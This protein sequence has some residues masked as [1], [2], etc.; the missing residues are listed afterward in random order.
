MRL[1]RYL[2]LPAVLALVLGGGEPAATCCGPDYVK[3]PTPVQH[4]IVRGDRF[5][6]VTADG[7]LLAVDLRKMKVKEFPSLAKLGPMVD[8]RG[9]AICVSAGQKLL[10]VNADTGKITQELEIDGPLHAFGF[11]GDD[12][13]F[14]H[15]ARALDLID[16]KTARA[17]T[18]I[19]PG[20]TKQVASVDR[21]AQGTTSDAA[22]KHVYTLVSGEKP[23]VAV[24]D[25]A[26]A[27]VI[28][29]RPIAVDREF[30]HSD[31]QI[32]GKKMYYLNSINSYGIWLGDHLGCIDLQTGK[33]QQLKLPAGL[34]AHG[35]LCAGPDGSIYLSTRALNGEPR[36]MFRYDAEGKLVGQVSANGGVVV[37]FWAGDAVTL[38]RD[39][40]YWG[41]PVQAVN[42]KQTVSPEAKP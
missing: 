38:A 28:E 19:E 35:S 7:K 13:L 27:K 5:I 40:L 26:T 15:R 16:L 29:I 23:G 9:D 41:V 34:T 11:A 25:V 31:I 17:T 14:V 22:G 21:L 8:A 20:K 3:L 30:R 6:A 18:V 24:I 10:L 32:V 2:L 33:Q 37:G 4:S 39:R 12:H 42:S 36:T 1:A